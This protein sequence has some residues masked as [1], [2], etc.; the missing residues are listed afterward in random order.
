V[1]TSTEY[2]GECAEPVPAP[3]AAR[4]FAAV[5]KFYGIDLHRRAVVAR[6]RA[7]DGEKPKD[8]DH[9]LLWAAADEARSLAAWYALLGECEVCP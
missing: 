5:S 8:L 7:Q 2:R 1:T 9:R 3:S 6:F 4:D